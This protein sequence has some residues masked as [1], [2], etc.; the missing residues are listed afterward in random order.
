MPTGLPTHPTKLG[1]VPFLQPEAATIWILE[2]QE[3]IQSAAGCVFSAG[4]APICT[5]GNQGDM[6]RFG[7]ACP[8]KRH[9]RV[10]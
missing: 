6:S 7:P 3:W 2:V 4:V 8:S 5:N 10:I 9:V 1:S